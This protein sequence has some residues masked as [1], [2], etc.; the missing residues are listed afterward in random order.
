MF[1]LQN[2]AIKIAVFGLGYV[3]LPLAIEFSKKFDVVGFDVNSHRINQLNNGVDS[4]G[5]ISKSEI[6]S[7]GRLLFTDVIDRIADCDVFIVTVPTPVN[8]DK[9]PDLTPLLTATEMIGRYL[10]K[11]CTVIYES[12]VYPGMT[13]GECVP[14]LEQTSGLQYNKEFFVGDV[15]L[16]AH[17]L[18]WPCKYLQNKLNRDNFVKEL[19][20]KGGLR[21]EIL[22]SGMINVGDIIKI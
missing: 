4:T 16:K 3:G 6:G 22:S 5:E 18:C 21:C 20:H 13:E 1:D 8:S 11:N 2:N 12:T 19:L 15:K 10:R 17:D 7:A 14:L 9:L